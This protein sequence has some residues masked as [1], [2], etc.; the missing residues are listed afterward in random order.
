[1]IMSSP[2]HPREGAGERATGQE[3]CG[4]RP[5]TLTCPSRA[6]DMSSWP[7]AMA[8]IGCL[9]AVLFAVPVGAQSPM[10]TPS[11]AG[12]VGTIS[13]RVVDAGSG[14]SISDVLIRVDGTAHETLSDAD[15]LFAL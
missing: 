5:C 4:G 8:I 13:G 6:S 1:M 7:S 10:P 11:A 9:T 12:E 14:R 15:G 3:P 2:A